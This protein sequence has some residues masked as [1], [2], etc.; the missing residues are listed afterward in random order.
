MIDRS[1]DRDPVEALGEEYLER[2]RRGEDPQIGEY[3]DAH[4]QLADGIRE[5]FPTMLALE[6]LKSCSLSSSA[7]TI[8]FGIDQLPQLSDFRIVRELGRGGMGVVYEA[9]EQSL[10]RRVAV[11]V[12]PRKV[13]GD[14]HQLRRFHLEAQTAAR[15]HHTNIVPIFGVGNEHDLHF[16]VMQRIEGVSLEDIIQGTSGKSGPEDPT[17]KETKAKLQSPGS[18]T[19]ID[20]K[21]RSGSSS[22]SPRRDW[23]TSSQTGSRVGET[24]IVDRYQQRTEWKWVTNIGIQVADALSYAHA[25]GVLHRDIKPANIL[26]DPYGVAWVTDFGLATIVGSETFGEQGKIVGT[27]RY[28]SPEQTSGEQDTRSDIYGLGVTLYEMLTRKPAFNEKSQG[29]LLDSI[30]KGRFAKPREVRPAIPRDLEAIVLKAMARRSDDRY[31]SAELLLDDLRRFAEGRTVHARPRGT[32]KRTVLWARRNPSLALVS[33][34]LLLVATVSIVLVTSKWREAV[35]ENRRAEQNLALALESMDHILERFTSSWVVDPNIGPDEDDADHNP[36]FEMVVSDHGAGVLRDALK[37]YD[38][39]AQQ[40]P[41]E[42]RLQRDIAKV[43]RRVADMYTALGQYSRAELAYDRS[44]AI[45]DTQPNRNKPNNAVERARIR[46]QIG[47]ALHSRSQFESAESEFE[48]ARVLLS[49]DSLSDDPQCQVE[50]ARTHTNLGQ[51]QWLM[52]RR[53]QSKA[54]HQTAISILQ[55]IV[56]RFPHN[57]SY[58]VALARAY[59]A[60]Y[61]LASYSRQSDERERIRAAGIS[62]LEE[63]STD[64]PDVPDFQYELS[65]MLVVTTPR[66]R[67]GDPSDQEIELLDRSVAI[68][69]QLAERYPAIPR[70]RALLA[71]SLRESGRMT[72]GTRDAQSEQCY[73]ESLSVYQGLVAEFGDTPAYRVLYAMALRD[74][75]EMLQ[76]SERYAEARAMLEDAIDQQRVYVEMRPRNRL[77]K[78]ILGGIYGELAQTLRSLNEHE[79]ADRSL[80]NAEQYRQN[81]GRSRGP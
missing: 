71:R 19:S 78:S 65:E 9:E 67:R 41:T 63:L 45:L 53:D 11:K 80:E 79:A 47:L 50:L 37:F 59:R 10:H 38:R 36:G 5:H 31:Q 51:S 34:A 8:R 3:T 43:H 35:A 17:A 57:A 76:R 23:T 40:N 54:S 30:L 72:R 75:G 56:H 14:T 42:P 60:Y 52:L 27:L 74:F 4:P 66:R 55:S 62:I 39:F 61:P 22:S 18:T 64:F 16:F 2:R 13:L 12:F 21:T 26:L 70:Y 25:Q 73:L 32:V 28:M 29:R 46:N 69:R 1:E 77:G 49:D 44:L 33:A 58:D 7:E 24:D 20:L 6:Q 81:S 68:A 15:L 48:L